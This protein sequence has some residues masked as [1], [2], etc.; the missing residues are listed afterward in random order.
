MQLARGV[1]LVQGRWEKGVLRSPRASGHR[2]AMGHI[3]KGDKYLRGL[4][5]PTSHTSLRSNTD[6]VPYN[7]VAVIGAIGG[8]RQ[9]TAKCGQLQ[10]R[11][12]VESV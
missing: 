12:H 7:S 2:L 8:S 5:V 3:N 1:L 11:M 10:G 6:Q 4:L 9:Q